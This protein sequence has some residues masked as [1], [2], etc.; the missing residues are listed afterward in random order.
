[1]VAICTIEQSIG[2]E[3]GTHKDLKLAAKTYARGNV[4]GRT[5]APAVVCGLWRLETASACQRK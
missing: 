3:S 1:M 2:E 5:L 4:T